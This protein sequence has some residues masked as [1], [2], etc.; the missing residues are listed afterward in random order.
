MRILQV[1]AIVKGGAF[2]YHDRSRLIPDSAFAL[3]HED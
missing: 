3:S 1:T 2:S